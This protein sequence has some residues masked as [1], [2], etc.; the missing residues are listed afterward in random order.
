MKVDLHVHT[1]ERSGCT[2]ASEEEQVVA[3]MERGLDM[4][5]VTDHH[6]F[7]PATRVDEL[8]IRFAPFMVLPA[9]ELTTDVGDILVYGVTD[10]SIQE[11]S[12]NYAELHARVRRC[13]GYMVAAH[14]FR[15]EPEIPQG[16]SDLP[17][18]AFELY[19]I[20]TPREAEARIRDLAGRLGC[21]LLSN[22]DAHNTQPLGRFYNLLER[23]VSTAS[24]LIT[25]LRARRFQLVA[26]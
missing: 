10:E 26:D 3:A 21:A 8:N 18:D 24:E 17:P 11:G 23:R 6:R 9:I 16:L 22:S 13:N 19:S 25:E 14:P 15:Y 7:I 20:H 1:R 2:N 12:R 5:A 4:I